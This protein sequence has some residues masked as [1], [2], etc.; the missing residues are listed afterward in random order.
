MVNAPVRIIGEGINRNYDFF[1]SNILIF[2]SIM[3]KEHASCHVPS[4]SDVINEEIL[5]QRRV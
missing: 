5:M 2:I 4:F 3:V 1:Y